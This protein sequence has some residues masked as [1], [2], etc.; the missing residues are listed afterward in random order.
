MSVHLTQRTRP[1]QPRAPGAA[2]RQQEVD[3]LVRAPRGHR[4]T[5]ELTLTGA[6]DIA[7]APQLEAALRDAIVGGHRDIHLDL[8]EVGFLS[9]AGL[10]VL[11]TARS[12]LSKLQGRLVLEKPSWSVRRLV[13][14]ADLCPLL[15]LDTGRNRCRHNDAGI[16]RAAGGS[17]YPAA[18]AIEPDKPLRL[19]G[20][21]VTV[22][23]SRT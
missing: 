1:D 21:H 20:A 14:L 9:S 4:S 19:T 11:L 10:S 2:G 18:E 7:G 23:A 12:Q 6:L 8:A 3:G 22:A 15:G 16:S 13:C 17:R 5:Y